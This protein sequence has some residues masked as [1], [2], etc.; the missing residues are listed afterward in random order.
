MEEESQ[1]WQHSEQSEG[2]DC[3]TLRGPRFCHENGV[4]RLLMQCS[5]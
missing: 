4:G 1:M 2:P 5:S 3:V